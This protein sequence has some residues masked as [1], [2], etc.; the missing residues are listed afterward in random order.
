MGN[1]INTNNTN[2]VD[3]T[4]LNS[5]RPNFL[6][7]LRQIVSDTLAGKVVDPEL[8]LKGAD[9]GGLK[10][11]PQRLL[12]LARSFADAA[13]VVGQVGRGQV[14]AQ[15]YDARGLALEKQTK[16]VLSADPTLQAEALKLSDDLKLKVD[17]RDQPVTLDK[18]NPKPELSKPTK[19]TPLAATSVEYRQMLERLSNGQ[20]LPTQAEVEKLAGAEVERLAKKGV[21][22]ENQ[23]AI[24][25]VLLNAYGMASQKGKDQAQYDKAKEGYRQAVE[26]RKMWWT[27]GPEELRQMQNT[28]QTLSGETLP[29][30]QQLEALV[31]KRQQESVNQTDRR[32][33]TPRGPTP[34]TMNKNQPRP[35]QRRPVEPRRKPTTRRAPTVVERSPQVTLRNPPILV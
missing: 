16:E 29:G 23:E 25:S 18:P 27:V 8:L 14:P 26:N 21:P 9:L 4:R 35:T 2:R 5:P 13:R 7:V 1:E 12:E 11:Q 19:P 34:E 15:N 20:N 22:K 10:A 17:Q 32:R 28:Y 31:K 30:Q 33:A 6:E 24:R 3:N